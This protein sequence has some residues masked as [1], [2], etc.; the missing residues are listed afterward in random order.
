MRRRH[1]VANRELLV[2]GFLDPNCRHRDWPGCS[3]VRFLGFFVTYSISLRHFANVAKCDR[4]VGR[5]FLSWTRCI[6]IR[7]SDVR[8]ARDQDS[9]CA[10]ADKQANGSLDKQGTMTVQANTR[11]E[12]SWLNQQQQTLFS[13]TAAL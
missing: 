12:S 4:T 3:L 5:D 6:L 1:C 9:G 8:P 10:S 2:S 11:K 13:F 7:R